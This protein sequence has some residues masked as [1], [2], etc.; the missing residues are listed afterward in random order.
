MKLTMVL[1][2]LALLLTPAACRAGGDPE[3]LALDVEILERTIQ[4]ASTLQASKD[5]TLFLNITADEDAELHL[6]GYDLVWHLHGGE[7]DT[8]TLVTH[9]TG[10]FA[11]ELHVAALDDEHD[12]AHGAEEFTIGTLEVQPR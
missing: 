3:E 9:A 10:R 6:H 11:L 4:G 2:A 8:F 7:T 12:H 1:T 5:D